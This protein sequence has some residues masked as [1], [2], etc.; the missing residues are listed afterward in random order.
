MIGETDKWNFYSYER[1]TSKNTEK[2]TIYNHI[3]GYL[4]SINDQNKEDYCLQ[5][6]SAP[7]ALNGI[8]VIK[9]TYPLKNDKVEY[10]EAL[11]QV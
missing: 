10:Y 1:F 11:K 2:G 9:T 4:W 5:Q 7:T 3:A 8:T 6:T